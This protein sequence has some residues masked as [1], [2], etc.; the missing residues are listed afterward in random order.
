MGLQEN[1]DAVMQAIERWNAKDEQYYEIYTDD[2]V[3]HGFPPDVPPNIEGIRAMFG[4]MWVAFP[5]LHGDLQHVVAEEDTAAVHF[6]VSG[7]HEGEFMGIAPTGK[8]IDI[9]VMAFLRFN[10]EAKIVERWTRMDEVALLTQLG[11]MPAPA[12]APA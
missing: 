6:R 10:D 8:R 2:V 3:A 9:E 5:D 1:K 4:S 11:V 12:E 7:M